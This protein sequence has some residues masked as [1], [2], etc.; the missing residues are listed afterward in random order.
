MEC[1]GVEK[2]FEEGDTAEVDFDT[3]SVTNVGS[4]ERLPAR[5]I[6]PQLLQIVNAG[7]IFALLEQE[8]SIA[9]RP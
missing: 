1:S 2:I 5:T 4:G 9:P 3:G 6:P 7:G 8:G